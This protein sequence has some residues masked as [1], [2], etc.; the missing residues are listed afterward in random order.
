MNTNMNVVSEYIPSSF[1][2]YPR[3]VHAHTHRFIALRIVFP[4]NSILRGNFDPVNSRL[5]DV[6]EWV[7]EHVQNPLSLPPYFVLVEKP[8]MTVYSAS[9]GP[10]T[11]SNLGWK[12]NSKSFT[13]VACDPS[14]DGGSFTTQAGN[15]NGI[16]NRSENITSSSFSFYHSPYSS[17]HSLS[18][19]SAPAE[20]STTPKLTP[21]LAPK[22]SPRP[23]PKRKE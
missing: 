7:I 15:E 5:G 12:D 8:E 21:K 9:S 6:V 10:S 19:S 22:F 20:Q 14:Y 1:S 3:H 13:V 11:L 2:A 18:S 16:K 17:L 4:D 23:P